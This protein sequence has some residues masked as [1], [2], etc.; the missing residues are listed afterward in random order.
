VAG[1]VHTSIVVISLSDAAERDLRRQGGASPLGGLVRRSARLGGAV[2]D[3]D[4]AIV[5]KG[6]PMYPGELGCY[7]SHYAAWTAFLDSGVPQLLV[8]EDDTI[9]DWGFLAK[10]VA[11]DLQAAGIAYLRLYAKRPCAFRPVLRNAIEQQRSLIGSSTGRPAPGP[12]HREGAAR[13]VR[14]PPCRPIDDELDR[15]WDPGSRPSASSLSGDRGLHRLE[16]RPGAVRPVHHPPA[17]S[18]AALP[19]AADRPRA[20]AAP[21]RPPPDRLRQRTLPRPGGG[22]STGTEERDGLLRRLRAAVATELGGIAGR[23]PFALVDFPDHANVGDSAIWLG[24]TAFFRA[25][26]A[27][28]AYVASVRTFSEPALR[29]A[30]PEGPILIHGG[31]NFGDLWPRHQEFRER[32]LER[33]RGQDIVQL[34]QSIHYDDPRRLVRT[35]RAIARHGRFLLLVRDRPSLEFARAHFD[36]PVRLCPDPALCLGPLERTGVPTADVLCLRT[37]R[38][39]VTAAPP[40]FPGFGCGWPIG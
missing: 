33:F 31:G 13:F 19:D 16:H 38:E 8:L 4:D 21:A 25:R 26:G 5:A 29:A 11:V 22:M 23:G 14:T 17:A 32:L 1:T 3:P 24:T 27:E 37:D 15:S 30:L 39:R 10:L 9:V 34:P 35:A 18:R 7:A 2:H 20:Q 28:P 36:C 6:R 40:A 12:A